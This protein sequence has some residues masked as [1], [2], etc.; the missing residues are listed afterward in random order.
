MASNPTMTPAVTEPFTLTIFGA[1]G[2]LGHK[3]TFPALYRMC[4]RGTL[5]VPVVAVAHSDWTLDD[6]PE[7]IEG[8]RRQFLDTLADWPG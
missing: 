8:V 1:T 5:T 2:D 7:R 4:K 3:M 6:L